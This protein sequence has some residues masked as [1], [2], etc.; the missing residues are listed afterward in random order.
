MH[1][2]VFGQE[3]QHSP[4]PSS[5]GRLAPLGGRPADHPSRPMAQWAPQPSTS[6]VEAPHY[7]TTSVLEGVATENIPTGRGSLQ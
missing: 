5:W 1:T 3:V 4:T 7:L 2:S 6:H